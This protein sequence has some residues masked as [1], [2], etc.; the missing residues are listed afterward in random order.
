MYKVVEGREFDYT[1]HT[2]LSRAIAPYHLAEDDVHDV[3]NLFQYAHLEDEMHVVDQ[4]AARQGD[5]IEFFAEIDLLCALATC[6]SGDF[7]A[8]GSQVA[9]GRT[10]RTQSDA[11]PAPTC[12]PLGVVIYDIDPTLLDGW[13]S[14]SSPTVSS[15]YGTET[16]LGRFQA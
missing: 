8:P 1:C 12:K 4:V 3:L 7:S 2:L 6:H 16:S 13:K 5:Y 11:D 10:F 14:P 9:G 15:V